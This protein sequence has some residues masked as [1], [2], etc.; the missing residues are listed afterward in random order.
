MFTGQPSVSGSPEGQGSRS[1]PSPHQ[2]SISSGLA[3]G[4][5]PIL[6]T[7]SGPDSEALRGAGFSVRRHP[8]DVDIALE[9][10]FYTAAFVAPLHLHQNRTPGERIFGEVFFTLGMLA[11]GIMQ[12]LTVFGM[13]SYLS[14]RQ[15]GYNDEFKLGTGLFATGGVFLSSEHSKDLCGSFSHI[16]LNTLTGISKLNMPDGA[17]YQGTSDMPMFH[18]YKLPS[19]SWTFQSVG[20]HESFVEKELRVVHDINWRNTLEYL[21]NFRVE[22]GV[23]LVIMVGWLWYHVLHELRKIIKFITVLYHFQQEGFAHDSKETTVI[24][25]PGDDRKLEIVKLTKNAFAVGCLTTTMR[26]IVACMMLIWG[27][28]L[29][30]ASSNKLSLVLNSLAIGIVFELDVIIAYAVIDQKTMQRIEDLEPIPVH[31]LRAVLDYSYMLEIILSAIMLVGVFIAAMLVRKHQVDQH[32]RQLH[33]AASLCLFAGSVPDSQPD[34]IAPVPGFCESLLSLTCAPDVKLGNGNYHGPCLVTDQKVFGHQHSVM[35]YA[36]GELFEGMYDENGHRRSMADW[37]APLPKLI[38]SKTWTDDQYLNLF[39]KVC[40]QLYHPEI[41][42]DQRMVNQQLGMTM[43]SAPF[44][45]KRDAL[46]DAV[47]NGANSNFDGWSAN[48]DLKADRIIKALDH[49]RDPLPQASSR[50]KDITTQSSPDFTL[51]PQA[52]APAPAETTLSPVAASSN[53]LRMSGNA[54]RH[55]HNHK[56]YHNHKTL[57]HKHKT[58]HEHR[59]VHHKVNQHEHR[60]VYRKVLRPVG[61]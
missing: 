25:N 20:S 26:I 45:C 43:Y 1:L 2:K 12:C 21:N 38:D 58:H 50:K 7:R 4:D 14:E 18:S 31:T 40:V 36:D 10:E 39:R 54:A 35:Q 24:V 22:Y 47:F 60:E 23:L 55:Q 9:A 11:V 13:A 32:V 34:V 42:P 41:L 19:G 30:T 44:Y 28:S 37:G 33:G 49:C 56:I 48:F 27:T 53:L 29:L 59:E 15:A 57:H 51:P 16:G 52:P 8:G 17:I 6:N 5:T 61:N 3:S 46:F